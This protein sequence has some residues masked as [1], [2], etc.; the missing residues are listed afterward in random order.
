M[1]LEINSAGVFGG[2]STFCRKFPLIDTDKTRSA[3]NYDEALNG[4]EA[5]KLCV[6]CVAVRS[7]N[8]A[9]VLMSDT[10]HV[11]PVLLTAAGRR[12]ILHTSRDLPGDQYT[13]L[14]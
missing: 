6:A 7:V 4:D 14:N 5:A 11:W 10:A 9:L 8:S 1:L 2:T 13:C 3:I 12:R